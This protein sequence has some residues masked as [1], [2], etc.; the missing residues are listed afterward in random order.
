MM[1]IPGY[2]IEKELGRGGTA[3]V[4]LAVQK[5]FGRLVAIK[6]VSS[7]FTNDPTFGKRFV[8]ESRIV[9]QLMHPHIVQVHDVGVADEN[10]YLV[11]E[12]LRGG[13]LNRKLN[14]GLHMQQV[15]QVVRDIARALEF[16]H[17]KGYVH[18]DIKPENIL[19]REEGSAVLSDFGI[20]RVMENDSSMTRQGTVV[21]TPQYMSPEQAAGKAVDGRSDIYSL[22]IVFFKML[23]GEVPFKADT[24]IAIGIKHIQDPVPSLPEQLKAFQGIMNKVLSKNPND[25]FQS[26]IELERAVDA[27]RV[28]GLVPNSVIKTDVVST[29]EILAVKQTME[30]AIDDNGAIRAEAGRYSSRYRKRK[31]RRIGTGLMICVLLVG[32]LAGLYFSPYGEKQI[33]KLLSSYG[34]SEDPDLRELWRDASALRRDPSQSLSAVVAAHRRVLDLDGTHVEALDSIAGLSAQWKQD[35]SLAIESQ[36][37]ALAES[38]LKEAASV[39][40]NDEAFSALRERIDNSR[41]AVSLVQ[42]TQALIQSHGISDLPSATTAVQ[43]YKEALRLDPNVGEAQ[44]ELI[45]LAKFFTE[46]A[47]EALL[48]NDMTAAISYLERASTANEN[49]A[50]LAAVREKIQQA[51][52]LQG[53]LAL[54][55]Q[56]ASQLRANHALIYPA[57]ENAAELYRRVLA[58]DPGNVIAAQGL[59]EVFTQV[60]GEVTQHIE[61]GR[62]EQVSQIVDRATQIGF[63]STKVDELNAL[64]K[65]EVDRQETVKQLLADASRHFQNGYITEPADNNVVASA[66]EV[67]RL[68]PGN[69][70]ALAHLNK[71]AERLKEVADQAYTAGLRAEALLYLDLALTVRPDVPEWRVIRDSW[72]RDDRAQAE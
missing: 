46:R 28:E 37:V 44:Q 61:N 23:T 67:I 66:R 6:V 22:G 62:L 29:D 49:I 40:Q 1:E 56:Q 33:G 52:A 8:R 19:F 55:L 21:G 2:S 70:Q 3:R 12:F 58:T 31:K 51:N 41:R 42:T 54:L 26:G 50:G 45:T 72:S 47:D 25:R 57:G 63:E 18:R 35:I 7:Q 17:S 16:A 36:N 11:M 14:Q 27:L 15:L 34:L 38:K 4:Y 69:V 59:D 53:E 68:D 13:D 65:A 10:Y 43:S 5:K 32:G 64:H 60:L 30:I 71:S 48:A 24:A 20:A 9:A 39:F